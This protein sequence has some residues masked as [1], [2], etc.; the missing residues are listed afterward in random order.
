MKFEPTTFPLARITAGIIA[1]QI[2]V[3]ER[4]DFDH[5]PD[6]VDKAAVVQ[7][8]L[9]RYAEHFTPEDCAKYCSWTEH[10]SERIPERLAC[11]E[12]AKLLRQYNSDQV[13]AK[14]EPPP[15]SPPVV[16]SIQY[17]HLVKYEYAAAGYR[18]EGSCLVGGTDDADARR[19]FQEASNGSPGYTILSVERTPDKLDPRAQ[20]IEI[21]SHRDE[22]DSHEVVTRLLTWIHEASLNDDQ[23]QSLLDALNT[24]TE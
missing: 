9:Q 20:I 2:A 14:S 8:I 19:L 6:S 12:L 5:T 15:E 17:T 16:A 24:D 7:T 18:T 11:D 10:V 21:L 13:K 3:I 4:L 22:S 23:L 1:Y